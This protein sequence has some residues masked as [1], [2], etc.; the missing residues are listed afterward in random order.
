[1]IPRTLHEQVADIYY[2]IAEIERRA[3]NRKRTG[4]I[5]EVGTG[6]NAG[7]YRV[8]ISA[9]GEKAYIGP[10]M[11]QRT[12]AAGKV[13][14]DVVR[15][16]GE[17]VD[18]ISESGDLTDAVIDMSTYSNDNDRE[19]GDDVPLHIKVDGDGAIIC[20]KLTITADV[21]IDGDVKINGAFDVDGSSFTHN[22]KNV[23]ATHGHV[24]AP[25]GPPGPPV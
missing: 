20:G 15:K 3:R 5:A 6:E 4:V 23:G 12:V 10:W 24:T 19:N 8:K 21:Q 7:K 13:K 25:P 9:P 1:M 14:I 17:Q 11:K 2:R 16:V 18:V 22:G